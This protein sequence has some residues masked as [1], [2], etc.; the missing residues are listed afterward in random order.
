MSFLSA[1]DG[2]KTYI[3]CIATIGYALLGF[4]LKTIDIN[5]MMEMIFAALGGAGLRSGV[6]KAQD[7]AATPTIITPT[8]PAA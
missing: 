7:A 2:Q 8:T 5:T 3:V 6:Q 1:I 4:Y